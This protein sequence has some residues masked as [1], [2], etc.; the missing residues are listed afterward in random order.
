VKRRDFILALGGAATT[1]PLA[2]RAQHTLKA[3]RIGYLAFRSPM[4]ADDAFFQG[5]RNF[6]WMEGQNIFVERR[7]AAGNIDQLKDSAAELV[8]LRVDVIVTVAT[9]A[10]QAA[11]D[12]TASI[13]IVFINA[14]D[15]V[16]QGF[17]QSLA[18]P[19]GNITGVAFDASPD[20]TAKQAQLI[21]E[22]VP[23]ASRLAVLW[24]PAAP[25]MHSYF[26]V[27][28][29]AA[30]ALR[31]NLQ[32][33][34][35]QDPSE[36]ERA[37][38]AMTREHSDALLVLSDSFTTFYRARLAELAAK[39]RLP[40][41]Y[42]HAQYIEAGGLMSYGPSISDNS[43]RAAGF[44]DKILKGTK[45]TDL[46]AQQP[47]KFELV[48]NLKTAKALGLEVPPTLLARADEVIE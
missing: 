1:W 30:S 48:I 14:G 16:G 40:A 25:V 4:S 38:D 41:L 43:G 32:S 3:A 47:T 23:K 24:N 2:A 15:P 39:H 5:L 22:T 37:F 29:I 21:I 33:L 10:T 6:G 34:E 28:K 7:F 19:G 27:V 12:A 42:G 44:V 20:I 35:V 45:P 11:K 17:V 8:H 13:P 31:V 9:A 18:H 36:L 26:S 46:P